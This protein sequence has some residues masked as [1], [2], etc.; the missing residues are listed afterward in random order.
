MCL[1]GLRLG[2]QQL[3]IPQP[4]LAAPSEAQQL[5][6]AIEARGA[7]GSLQQIVEAFERCARHAAAIGEPVSARVASQGPG[8]EV[9]GVRDGTNQGIAL[10]PQVA[11]RDGRSG[12]GQFGGGRMLRPADRDQSAER[13]LNRILVRRDDRDVRGVDLD[14]D[15]PMGGVVRP[16]ARV[17]A[18]QGDAVRQQ[19][20]HPGPVAQDGELRRKALEATAKLRKLERARGPH[21]QLDAIG[22]ERDTIRVD[23]CDP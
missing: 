20:G 22:T 8:L 9:A 19:S 12:P 15:R 3:G 4:R 7:A 21:G 16:L 1:P 17:D 5:P 13:N 6:G 18:G 2:I 14:L 11:Q 23:P 10:T